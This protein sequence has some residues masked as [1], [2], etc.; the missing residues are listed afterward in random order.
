M[1]VHGKFFIYDFADG[2]GILYI[3]PPID[4]DTFN[5]YGSYSVSDGLYPYY[6]T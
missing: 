1:T 3:S 2:D 6:I 4:S 5:G